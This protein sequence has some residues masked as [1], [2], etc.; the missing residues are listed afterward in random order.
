ME[1]RTRARVA[2]VLSDREVVLNKGENDGVTPGMRFAIIGDGPEIMDPE[3][4]RSLGSVEIAKT[5]V[6]IVRVEPNYSIGRTFRTFTEGIENLSSRLFGPPRKYLE[7][8]KVR[9][10]TLEEILDPEFD[11]I[12][13]G[14]EAVQV[15]GEEFE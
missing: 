13:R 1:Q 11:R 8:L 12:G 3:T 9:D 7:T 6:K 2:A 10:K 4:G 5:I 14:D 15:F